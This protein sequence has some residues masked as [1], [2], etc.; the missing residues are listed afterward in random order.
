MSKTTARAIDRKSARQTISLAPEDSESFR[1]GRSGVFAVHAVQG[2]QASSETLPCANPIVEQDTRIAETAHDLNNALNAIRLHLDLLELE[3]G[4]AEKVRQRL[5]EIRP[6]VQHAAEITRRFMNPEK[7]SVRPGARL[8]REIALNPVLQRML[9]ILSAMLS[10]SAD[11]HLCLAPDLAGVVIDSAEVIR[12]VSNLVL[13]SRA[14][15]ARPALHTEQVTIETANWHV[16]GWVLLRVRDTGAGMS[17]ATRANIFQPSFT[18]KAP[19]EGAGLGLSSVLRMVRRAGGTIQVESAPGIG[20]E[21]TILFP[22]AA[23]RTS[24]NPQPSLNRRSVAA[25]VANG[26]PISQKSGPQPSSR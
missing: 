6:A 17:S 24:K 23:S 7:L 5:R 10:Q 26:R 22:S 14:A 11:L 21:V 15:L 13:N 2:H 9:P 8:A 3:S 16:P 20:T 18:T 19:G 12:I 4:N 1:S 25:S